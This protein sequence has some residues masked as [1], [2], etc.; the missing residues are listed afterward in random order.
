M[1]YVEI[2]NQQEDDSSEHPARQ[3]IV[4]PPVVTATDCHTHSDRVL[5]ILIPKDLAANI[6]NIKTH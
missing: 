4:C 6:G 3:S 2:K 1:E 5:I